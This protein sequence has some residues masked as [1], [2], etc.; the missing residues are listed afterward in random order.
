MDKIILERKWYHDEEYQMPDVEI[1]TGMAKGA[2]TLIIDWCV[3]NWVVW[4]ECPALWDVHGKAAGPIRNQQMLDDWEPDLII[5]YPGGAGTA[6]MV[7]RG[8]KAG[9]EVIKI[10]E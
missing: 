9:V 2:D 6:D 1:I 8:Q 5:A 7:R 10:D 3:V 4:H